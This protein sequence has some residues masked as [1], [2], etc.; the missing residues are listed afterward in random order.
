MGQ[1]VSEDH[2]EK[3]QGEYVLL[4]SDN[5]NCRNYGYY[6]VCDI[7]MCCSMDLSMYSN[8]YED[9]VMNPGWDKC[10]LECSLYIVRTAWPESAGH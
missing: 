7:S 9:C 8:A 4:F 1:F 3:Y 10:Y 2:S 5:V 6:A